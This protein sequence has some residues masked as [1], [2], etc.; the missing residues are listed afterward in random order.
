MNMRHR[1]SDMYIQAAKPDQAGQAAP[2]IYD[3]DP[4]LFDYLFTDGHDNALMFLANE[5]TQEI[6]YYSFSHCTAAV[7]EN[8]LVGIELG[9]DQKTLHECKPNTGLNGINSLTPE[10]IETIVNRVGYLEYLMP[11]IPDD[12]YYILFLATH[13]TV[14]NLGLGKRLLANAFDQARN[15]GYH[16]CELDVASNNKAVDFYLGNGMKI[17]SET[18]VVPLEQHNIPSHYRMVKELS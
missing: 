12:A 4:A 7:R 18:R 3:T 5:W 9:Y 16:T 2:L 1:E 14:R 11:P 10:G 13:R 15:Q 6:S 8:V 17:L